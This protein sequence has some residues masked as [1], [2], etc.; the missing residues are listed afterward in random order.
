M[1]KSKSKG[2]KSF[3]KKKKLTD[4]DKRALIFK[5][6]SQD[7]AIVMET[8]GNRRLRVKC[9]G[10]G[11]NGSEEGE[12]GQKIYLALIPGKFKKRVWINRGDL[13]LVNYRSFQNDK[14]DV[15]WK[16]NSSEIYK[17][18]SAKEVT[19]NFIS[20]DGTNN[21]DDIFEENLDSPE[22][23]IFISNNE[24]KDEIEEED[25]LNL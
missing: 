11:S 8:L 1:P 12:E 6:E 22:D 9:F 2:G 3:R 17:L 24:E 4:D 14:V 21:N 18:I 7:Y 15:I 13:V 20:I 16:Y 25:L 23:D 19:S 10:D 5:E